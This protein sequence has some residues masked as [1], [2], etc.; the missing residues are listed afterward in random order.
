LSKLLKEVLFNS[1]DSRPYNIIGTQCDFIKDTMTASLAF[2]ILLKIELNV[3]K[4]FD[5][6]NLKSI[7]IFKPP[8]NTTPRYLTLF[9]QSIAILSMHTGEHIF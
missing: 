3:R 2:E 7:D 4:N 6:D 5:L 1:K 8:I 9:D